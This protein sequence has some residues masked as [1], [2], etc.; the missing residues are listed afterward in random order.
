MMK[1]NEDQYVMTIGLMK[2]LMLP[3]NNSGLKT[4]VSS[5]VN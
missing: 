5:Y 3:V 2:M 1:T 4:L